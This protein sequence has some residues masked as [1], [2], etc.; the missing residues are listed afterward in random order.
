[1]KDPGGASLGLVCAFF[2]SEIVSSLSNWVGQLH[3]QQTILEVLW[4]II[5]EDHGSQF[6][7]GRR[8]SFTLPDGCTLLLHSNSS[9][10]VH[11]TE[12]NRSRE[13][14]APRRAMEGFP[15]NKLLPFPGELSI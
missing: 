8:G 4:N 5:R 2:L 15:R 9:S 7:R 6:A 13:Q 11:P 3:Q 14:H 10:D 12:A 1:M